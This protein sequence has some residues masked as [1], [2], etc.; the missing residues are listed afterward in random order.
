MVLSGLARVNRELCLELLRAGDVELTLRWRDH[1]WPQLRKGDDPD[2]ERLLAL[3]D[4]PLSGPPDVTVRHQF[5]PDW[6][7]PSRGRLVVFQPWE[8]SQ[9][10][11]EWAEGARRADEIWAYSRF[12]RDAWVRSG[13]AAEK[14]RLVPLGFN[15]RIFTPEGPVHPLAAAHTVA[16]SGAPPRRRTRFLFIGGTLERKGADLLLD[17]YRRAF[18]ASDDVSLVV[19]DLGG[20]SFYAGENLAGAFRKASADR[21]GP[22]VVYLDRDLSDAELASLYRACTCVVLPYRGEGFALPPLEGMACGLP[23]IVTAGGPTDDYVDDAA[24]LRLPFRR[25]PAARRSYW[26]FTPTGH[27]QQL[28]PDR[29]ALVAALRW[30]Y[31]HP[32]ETRG[33]GEAARER[34]RDSWTWERCAARARE[35]LLDLTLRSR[36][37]A[38]PRSDARR[39]R[40]TEVPVL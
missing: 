7:R 32:D 1:I 16:P 12:V 15:P 25:R 3:R 24:G 8:Y 13:I 9:V 37:E 27:P 29:E 33:R 31:E 22:E 19:R 30:V 10:P 39:S 28:E 35:R 18:S 11:R 17:A 23:A 2:L 20:R 40:G 5:P 21:S 34:V 6:R 26:P 36:D 38:R 4:R 14:V